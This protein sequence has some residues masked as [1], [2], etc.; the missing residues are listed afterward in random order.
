LGLFLTMACAEPVPPAGLV[1]LDP[2]TGSVPTD[3]LAR[4]FFHDFGRVPFGERVSHRFRFRN[5]DPVTVRITQAQSSCGCSVADMKRV[6]SAG[7]VLATGTPNTPGNL[8]EVPP[9]GLC[10][11]EVRVDTQALAQRDA[12]KLVTVRVG[13][14][15]PN[16]PWITLEASLHVEFG[17]AYS[18]AT[19][20]MNRVPQGVGAAAEVVIRRQGELAMTLAEVE[21]APAGFDVTLGEDPAGAGDQWRL[22][23]VVP[24]GLPAGPTIGNVRIA[25]RNADGTPGRPISIPVIARVLADITVQPTQLI[26]RGRNDAARIEQ[27]ARV[28]SLVDGLFFRIERAEV[29]G[30]GSEHLEVELVAVNPD[31]QGRARVWT[32]RVSALRAD[33]T[34]ALGGTLHLHLDDPQTPRLDLRYAGILR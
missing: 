12:A 26:L 4:P 29:E 5:T 33:V 28:E 3:P 2:Q 9:D 1:P 14:D 25:T 24:P 17:F 23:V 13:T 10:E 22:S 27:E 31:A 8:L 6:D 7:R 20:E 19:L 21:D 34:G 11:I 32:V 30:A 18:P 16:K 15:S